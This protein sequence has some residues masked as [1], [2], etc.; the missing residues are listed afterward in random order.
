M[1]DDLTRARVRLVVVTQVDTGPHLATERNWRMPAA[2]FTAVMLCC[3]VLCV[4]TAVGSPALRARLMGSGGEEEEATA[5]IGGGAVT[6]AGDDSA[7]HTD[8]RLKAAAAGVERCAWTD[9]ACVTAAAW[10]LLVAAMPGDVYSALS[11]LAVSLLHRFSLCSRPHRNLVG[12][13]MQRGWL[14]AGWSL[15]LVAFHERL[16][17]ASALF[18]LLSIA[19]AGAYFTLAIGAVQTGASLRVRH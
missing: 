9:V 16:L 4:S 3:G 15:A 5:A 6:A 8:G 10:Q 14:S 19:T 13:L 11:A 18:P 2:G 1:D 17:P 12:N 7:P